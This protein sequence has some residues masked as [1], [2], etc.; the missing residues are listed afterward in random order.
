MIKIEIKMHIIW[1]FGLKF[2]T[3]LLYESFV[4]ITL[5]MNGK[6]SKNHVMFWNKTS[7]GP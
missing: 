5:L 6:N 7:R 1:S 2:T 4:Q 3:F